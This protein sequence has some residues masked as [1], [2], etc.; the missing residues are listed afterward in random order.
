IV[1]I[2]ASMQVRTELAQ[3]QLVP[4]LRHDFFVI[5]PIG[6]TR[7]FDLLLHAAL[8]QREIDFA[9]R[10]F[11]KEMA[12]ERGREAKP[13]PASRPHAGR[14]LRLL[15][16]EDNEVNQ[17]VILGML[18]NM[19]HSCVQVADG[20]EAVRAATPG[21]FD[22]ILLDVQMPVM[23]GVEA[24]KQIRKKLGDESC[25]PIIAMTAHAL[26]GDREHY[27]SIGMDDYLPK[28]IRV[29]TLATVL[30]RLEARL[31]PPEPKAMDSTLPILDLEQLADLRG[32]PASPDEPGDDAVDGLI[33]M[34]RTQTA[35]RLEIMQSR[36]ALADWKGL[37]ETAHSLRG[38]SAS[39]GYPRVSMQCKDIEATA[40]TLAGTPGKMAQVAGA[41]SQMVA[42]QLADL[43][44]LVE[45][46]D[47]ALAAWLQGTGQPVS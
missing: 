3:R 38:A 43:R 13:A 9:T 31:K 17:R 33:N 19:G 1:S 26:P 21:L 28:P 10:P 35:E 6:R 14:T 15:L 41:S 20:L 40:R 16:A 11:G 7:M 44:T 45:E 25:P 23:D 29:A 39:V 36:L 12:V 34:F 46:A 42:K 4:K 47:A 32:L 22:A 8:G 5:R 27:L 2:L 30:G 18:R 24:M 37:S